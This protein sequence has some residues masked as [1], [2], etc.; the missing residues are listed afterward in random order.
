MKEAVDAAKSQYPVDTPRSEIAKHLPGINPRWVTMYLACCEHG[1]VLTGVKDAVNAAKSQFPAGTRKSEIVQQLAEVDG[2]TANQYKACCKSGEVLTGVKDAVDAAI[3]QFP[4]GT[5]K[6]AIAEKLGIGEK[7]VDRYK[8]N[9]KHIETIREKRQDKTWAKHLTELQEM[10]RDKKNW[11][12]IRVRATDLRV[13]LVAKSNATP[14]LYQYFNRH[15][16]AK[17]SGDKLH[18][19]T[20]WK[21]IKDYNWEY[22]SIAHDQFQSEREIE[23]KKQEQDKL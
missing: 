9:L 12:L 18:N 1:Q 8:S 15:F 21:D 19:H 7:K 23:R 22:H 16:G 17:W 14:A 4:V 10:S 20:H 2:K 6:I 13:L 11:V 3:T 5:T